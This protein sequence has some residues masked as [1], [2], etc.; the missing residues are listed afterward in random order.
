MAYNINDFQGV[1]REL[2]RD[3][4]DIR[5]MFNVKYPNSKI[6]E[7]ILGEDIDATD[8][9]TTALDCNN[10]TA[11]KCADFTKFEVSADK[12]LNF[13]RRLPNCLDQMTPDV[14]REMQDDY[15]NKIARI[16]ARVELKTIINDLTTSS[17]AS[18]IVQTSLI[19][20]IKK[21]IG[22][23]EQKGN[24][25]RENIVLLINSSAELDTSAQLLN[26]NA[27][28]GIQ[29]VNYSEIV[30]AHFGL[31]AVYIVDDTLMNN[32]TTTGERKMV[33]GYDYES[34]MVAIRCETK[35]K[36]IENYLSGYG[37]VL[38]VLFNEQY[39]AKVARQ[40]KFEY[41]KQD[42]DAFATLSVQVDEPVI[43]SEEAQ[44]AEKSKKATK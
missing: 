10:P 9:G 11:A 43:E 25:A 36:W 21:V 35:P 39:G 7:F 6:A 4:L 17:G 26:V 24:V 8:F 1:L 13:S 14:I 15:T 44:V 22:S 20:G 2:Q 42:I 41:S 16:S 19:D 40:N 31:K 38:E 30:R 3:Y 33:I 34:A 5:K 37:H 29:N 23:L 18:G 12:Y 28:A 32:G 27:N